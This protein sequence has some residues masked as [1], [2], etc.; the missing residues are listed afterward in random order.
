V[1]DPHPLLAVWR[2]AA[3]G[4][5]P[6]VDGGVTF[7]PPFA[8]GL[9]AVLSFT[10]HAFLATALS[11]AAFAGRPLDGIGAA[12]DPSVLL[13]LAGSGGEVGVIDAT[14]VARGR[15]GGDLPPRPEL[16]GHPRVE[17]AR[18][19]RADVRV[20]GDDRGLVTLGRGHA[21][22]TEMSVETFDG[23]RN[24]NGRKLIVEAL[25]L[26]PEGEFAFAAVSPGHA[27]SLRAFLSVG[28]VPLG[29][30]VWIRPG[31]R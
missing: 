22:R 29:S 15:G 31:R 17:H 7:V 23:E 30:E 1:I 12:L 20:F 14:L 16:A 26:V 6:P 18:A 19:I 8:E 24:G 25:R 4:R 2:D 27:R 11:P 13:T 10:G 28:F 21:G 9:E 5:F 3:E